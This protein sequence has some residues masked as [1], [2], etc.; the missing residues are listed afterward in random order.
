MTRLS[1]WRP[2]E[3]LPIFRGYL[4]VV[5]G[6]AVTRVLSLLTTVVLARELG[7]TAFGE[8]SVFLAFLIFW[9]GNDFLDVTFV[10][11][12]NASTGEAPTEYLRAVF[13]LKI[14][15]NAI[16]LAVSF[17]LSRLLATG[18]FGK[19]SLSMPIFAALVCGIGLNFLSLRAATYQ[20]KERFASYAATNASFYV[21]TALVVAVLVLGFKQHETLHVYETYIAVAILAGVY[22]VASLA[23]TV[24]SLRFERRRIKEVFSFSGWLFP[25]NIS[26]LIFQQLD[27]FLV[28]A[29]ASLT[30]VGEYSAA[31][32]VVGV[33]SLLTGTLAPALLPRATRAAE[34][35]MLIR[36]YLKQ[37]AALSLGIVALAFSVW[38]AAPTIIEIFFGHEYRRAAD[39][40]RFLLVS[41]VLVGVY[42]PVSQL[43]LAYNQPRRMFYLN[44]VKLF[45]IGGAGIALV[46]AWKGVGA[47]LAVVLSD[48]AALGYVLV[49]LW[50]KITTALAPRSAATAP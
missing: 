26:F 5:L 9:V 45:V 47:A 23:A 20:A 32:R 7:A 4:L 14:V 43:L 33:V 3:W 24:R 13:V 19:P 11:Y 38:F 44:L 42:T 15:L 30:D 34:D 31:L 17:P 37:G 25:A 41:A 22:A 35:P 6:S 36:T 8:V 21:L 2:R 50:P 12:A 29:F 1:A 39:I 49:V 16:L 18:A 40:A 48:A 10:R 27:L 46:P 28:T